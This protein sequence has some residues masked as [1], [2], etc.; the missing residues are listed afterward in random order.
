MKFFKQF[1]RLNSIQDN[2][3][4]IS[5]VS[6]KVAPPSFFTSVG[7]KFTL[8]NSKVNQER[9]LDVELVSYTDQKGHSR[10]LVLLLRVG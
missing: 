6:A 8:W 9:K 2:L 4:T 10:L 5:S 1:S 7:R 3:Q